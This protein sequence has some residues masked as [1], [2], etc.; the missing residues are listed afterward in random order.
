MISS[1]SHLRDL[2]NTLSFFECQ[3][4]VNTVFDVILVV[5]VGG[6]AFG[7]GNHDVLNAEA[8][9][10]VQALAGLDDLLAVV[11]VEHVVHERHHFEVGLRP[12]RAQ[13]L[14][15]LQELVPVDAADQLDSR[16]AEHPFVHL[17]D[18]LFV[19]DVDLDQFLRSRIR[20]L[21]LGITT[22]LDVFTF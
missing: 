14:Q 13:R 12:L 20:R 17:Q 9:G 7:T 3:W 21:E 15:L 4:F 2:N 22:D 8:E 6:F 11:E 16:L 1:H 19:V 10:L 5:T 18:V